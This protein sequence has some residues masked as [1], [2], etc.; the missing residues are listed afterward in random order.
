MMMS[1]GECSRLLLLIELSTGVWVRG[2]VR[3]L[4]LERSVLD[5]NGMGDFVV[6]EAPVE[7]AGGDT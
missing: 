2:G 7:R 1:D 3:P 5:R 4:A 6:S